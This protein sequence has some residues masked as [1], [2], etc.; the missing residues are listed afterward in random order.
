M[1]HIG[2]PQSVIG[3]KPADGV[4]RKDRAVLEAITKA[5]FHNSADETA[6]ND[7]TGG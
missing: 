6:V 5:F 1:S 4:F 2:K 3:Q 7:Q